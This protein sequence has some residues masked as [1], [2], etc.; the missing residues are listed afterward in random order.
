[1]VEHVLDFDIYSLGATCARSKVRKSV[2]FETE[3]SRSLSSA[4]E[5]VLRIMRSSV[6]AFP[7]EERDL[8]AD[9]DP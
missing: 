5:R 1:M 8:L 3:A 7:E 4:S 2:L 6:P 9:H